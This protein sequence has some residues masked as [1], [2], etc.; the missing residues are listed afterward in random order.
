VRALVTGGAGFIGSHLV[1][2]LVARG[3]EVVVLDNL[4]TG[5]I[6]N[7]APDAEL[8]EG[9]V[10]DELAVAKAVAGCEVVYHQA[11]LGS[12]ARSI[13]RPLVSDTANI[14]GTLA[15]LE[16]AR[17][18]GVRRVVMASSS[19]VYGG[20]Q[21]VPT[22]ET[23]PLVPRS[24]YAVTKLTDEHY[25]RV[26]WE[27]HGR[28][29]VCL[30]YFNVYGPRQRPDSQYAAVIPLFIDALLTGAAPQVHGDGRQSRDF[31]F[32]ADAVQANLRAAAAPPDA[33]AGRAFNVAHG[34][35]HSLLDLLEILAGEVGVAVEPVHVEPRAGDVRHSHADIAAARRALGYEPTV[36]FSEGLAHTLAWFTAR[37]HA[38][39]EER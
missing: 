1:D 35:P 9:D 32:V 6:D 8:I 19:S 4:A 2:A 16:G 17:A 7:L 37:A 3:D 29:N 21:Q 34:A 38:V 22:P 13:E 18:A 20:A 10:A 39:P 23:V 28:E 31:T 27:L 5:R 33:C 24:P 15:V 11:A 30:R 25:A 26:F 14:H 12:V 36:G